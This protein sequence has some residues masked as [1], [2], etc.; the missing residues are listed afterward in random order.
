MEL[1]SGCCYKQIVCQTVKTER[2][3]K[4]EKKPQ[5]PQNPSRWKEAVKK[6]MGKWVWG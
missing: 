5:N 4:K 2:K 6:K 3:K 1:F